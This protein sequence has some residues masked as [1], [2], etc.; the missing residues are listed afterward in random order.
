[1]ANEAA[2]LLDQLMGAHRN[3]VPGDNVKPLQYTDQEVCKYYLCGFCPCD[4]FTNTRADMG[5]CPDIHDQ[6]LKNDYD[7]SGR[8]GDYGYESKFQHHLEDIIRDLDK[9]ICRGR[10]RL[11]RSVTAKIQGDE[12]VSSER[13]IRLNARIHSILVDLEV[14]GADG[15][16]DEARD[17]MATLEKLE[18][19]RDTERRSLLCWGPKMVAGYELDSNDFHEKMEMCDVCGSFLVIGDTQGRVDAHLLG[20]QHI[21]YAR[22]R[23]TITQLK[24]FQEQYDASR[25]EERLKRLSRTS[26]SP[27]RAKVVSRSRSPRKRSRSP[28]KR[29]RSRSPRRRSRSPK[30]SRGRRRSHRSRTPHRRSRRSRSPRRSDRKSRSSIS[31]RKRSKS[32][33]KRSKSPRKRS[34]SPRKRSKSPRKRSRSPR[35]RSKSPRKKSRSPRKRSESPKKSMTAE[36]GTMEQ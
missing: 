23:A 35:K 14:L 7:S 16:V 4:L 27:S 33:R 11:D 9:R 28:R 13:L 34:K 3:A 2:S 10:A 32:P 24:S 8:K 22:I 26:S 36:N 12:E 19:E 21:G 30:G 17:V 5:T 31:P 20:K 15:R 1:M 29:S 18:K 25:R 6:K